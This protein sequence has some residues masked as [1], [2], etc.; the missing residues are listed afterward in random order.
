[1][2]NTEDCIYE[3]PRDGKYAF[4]Y[5]RVEDMTED[6]KKMLQPLTKEEIDAINKNRVQNRGK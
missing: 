2:K 5:K 4:V 3:I 1:M 6:E